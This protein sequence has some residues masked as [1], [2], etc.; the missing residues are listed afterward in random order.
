MPLALA[1]AARS[2]VM[3]GIFA[4]SA[5]VRI[6]TSSFRGILPLGVLMMN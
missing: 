6:L 5:A 3:I 1:L 2:V 4:P